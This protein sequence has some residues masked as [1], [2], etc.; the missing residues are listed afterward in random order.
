MA[1]HEKRSW[2]V[3]VVAVPV[4]LV[5]ALLIVPQLIAAPVTEID[6]VPPMV[7]AIIGFVIANVLGNIV[8]AFT[9]PAEAE[10]HDLRDQQISQYG[11]RIGSWLVVA[12]AC[13]ALVLAMVEA[14]YFW[15]ANALFIGGMAASLTSAVAKIAAYRGTFQPW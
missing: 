3:L 9:N 5:Y 2:V 14:P 15:I 7:F 8:A 6:W 10:Q 4:L 1:F 11:V 13:A 12:G